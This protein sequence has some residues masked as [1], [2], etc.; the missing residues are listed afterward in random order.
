MFLSFYKMPT[1]KSPRH[2]AFLGSLLIER[3]MISTKYQSTADGV[4]G[5]EDL[6]SRKSLKSTRLIYNLALFSALGG[7]FFGYDTGAASSAISIVREEFHLEDVWHQGLIAAAMAASW[8]VCIPGGISADLF[9][10]RPVILAASIAYVTGAAV[11]GFAESPQSLLVGR[12]ILGVGIGLASST[13]TMYI[14]EMAPTN[15]RG[16]LVCLNGLLLSL[17]RVIGALVAVM[18]RS[19]EVSGWRYML[20]LATIPGLVQFVGFLFLPESPRWL[21]SKGRLEDAKQVLSSYRNTEMAAE[22]FKFIIKSLKVYENEDKVSLVRKILYDPNVR[23]AL[24]IGCLL[25]ISQQLSGINIVMYYSNSIMQMSGFINPYVVTWLSVAIT[26]INFVFTAVS[27]VTVDK[28]GRRKL[29]LASLAGV[30]LSLLLL[31]LSFVAIDSQSPLVTSFSGKVDTCSQARVCKECVNN[32]YCGFCK[33]G[34]STFC[35][36]ADPHLSLFGS[37]QSLCSPKSEQKNWSFYWC[38]S[39]YGW[40]AIMALVTYLMFYSPGIGPLPWTINSEIYPTWARST[41][42]SIATSFNWFFNLLTSFTFLSSVSVIDKQGTFGIYA[43]LSFIGLVTFY[44]FL[45]ETK[46]ISLDSTEDV[47][48]SR[49]NQPS[50]INRAVIKPESIQYVKIKGIDVSGEDDE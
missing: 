28:A 19:D 48:D 36:K 9:G 37:I 2:A 34:N 47:F 35:L 21:I 16:K 17:G 26:S 13:V 27:I 3:N 20:G 18:F 8:L 50:E 32:V 41:C 11:S 6:E 5:K 10:R 22:E 24:T 15:S 38:P 4:V 46:G 25:Q 29:V 12:V 31:S 33:V 14:G 45:P 42:N 30:T 39:D 7:F 44:L 49:S 23:K 40:M 1:Y 43:A